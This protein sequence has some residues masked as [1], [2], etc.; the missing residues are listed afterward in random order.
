MSISLTSLSRSYRFHTPGQP[1]LKH[2]VRAQYGGTTITLSDA[3]IIALT[4]NEICALRGQGLVHYLPSVANNVEGPDR[5]LEMTRA[6]I[7]ISDESPSTY[8]LQRQTM[9]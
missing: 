9:D 8:D 2:G 4:L 6:D 3:Q 1:D 5:H 7:E